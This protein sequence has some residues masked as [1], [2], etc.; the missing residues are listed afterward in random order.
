[1]KNRE[2]FE[3]AL[4]SR[5]PATV[6]PNEDLSLRPGH[7]ANRFQIPEA[8]I[9]QLTVGMWQRGLISLHTW[10][11]QRECSLQGWLDRGGTEYEF[12]YNRT[13]SGHVRVRLLAAGAAEKDRLRQAKIGFAAHQ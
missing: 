10:N 3:Q 1:M 5:A 12:F 7:E 8:D 11:G 9:V 6:S 2:D 4:L 13:D